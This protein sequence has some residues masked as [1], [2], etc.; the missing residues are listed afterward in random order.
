[1]LL[2]TKCGADAK[3]NRAIVWK[4]VTPGRDNDG[5]PGNQGPM[6]SLNSGEIFFRGLAFSQ[7]V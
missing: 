4:L 2:H 6:K 5:E 3:K 1:M 7:D